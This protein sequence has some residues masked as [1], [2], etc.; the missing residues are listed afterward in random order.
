MFQTIKKLLYFGVARYFRFFAVIKLKRWNPKIIVI[1]GSSGKTTLLHLI[2]SQ[3]GDIAK[4]SHHA[5]SSIGIPFDILGLH[6]KDLT[7][8]EWPMLFLAAPFKVFSPIPKEK[9]YVVEADCDRPHEGYFLSSFLKPEITLWTNVSRTHSMNFDQ[10]VK[11]GKFNKVEEAIAYEFG[12]FV[13]KTKKLVIL[14]SDD[15]L[16]LSQSDRIKCNVEKI[17]AKKSLENYKVELG[18]TVFTLD[19]VVFRFKYLLPKEVAVSILMCVELIKYLEV[20]IDKYFSKLELPPGR[21]SLFKGIKNITIIDSAY[22]ASLESMRAILN[23]F[24]QFDSKNKWIVLG[25][26]LEQGQEEREEHEKLA[27]IISK[28]NFQRIILMG[29]R[30]TKYTYP[31][32]EQKFNGSIRLEKFLNPKEV[33][34]YLNKN[35]MGGEAILFKGA[36][37]LEGVIENLLPD[38]KDVDKLDRREKVWE[39]RRKQWGL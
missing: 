16:V 33:L 12:Y 27:E 2:E 14:N 37:F 32:L 34:D 6:R 10:L 15:P 29:P 1:T 17:S 4:Y 26:M 25:D 39:K 31:L 9:I 18:G 5:N 7:L 35:I 13:E 19:G 22:N 38:K 23:M 20:K 11:P 28:Y 36:R 30:I 8:T 24:S 21:S 3:L